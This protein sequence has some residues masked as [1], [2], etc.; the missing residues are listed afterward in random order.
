MKL[1]SLIIILNIISTTYCYATTNNNGFWWG[2]FTKKAIGDNYSFWAETQVRYNLSFGQVGQ[3]LYRTGLL[4]QQNLNEWGLLYGYIQGNSS[5]EHR[6]TLQ[7]IRSYSII[8][9]LSLSS[10]IRYE[11]RDLE[12]IKDNASRLRIL[13]RATIPY[14]NP[15]IIWNEY[16]INLNNVSWNGKYR[17]DRNRLFIGSQY[18]IHES[19]IE[20]GY[21]NQF[22]KR[23]SE[24]LMEHILVTYLNF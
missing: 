5:K 4:S 23:E 9:N 1:K 24:N 21:L 7:H 14:T 18:K 22:T 6:Y 2:T 10:R 19:K 11:F 20:Y 3:I 15:L 13:L 17:F 12:N 16:F 8:E